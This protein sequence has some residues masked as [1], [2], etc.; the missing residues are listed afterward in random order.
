MTL[1]R[2]VVWSLGGWIGVLL[3]V[4]LAQAEVVRF[5]IFARTPL[6]GGKEFE[7]AGS[8]EV[9]TG[10]VHYALDPNLPQNRAIVDLALAPRSAAGLV[11]F[12]ADL[13]ILK[14]VDAARGNGCLLYE[15]NNRG[16]KVALSMFN[17]GGGNDLSDEKALGHGFLMRQGF[18]VVWSGWDGEL[19]PGGDRLRLAAPPAMGA[20]GPLSGLVRCEIVPSSA[21]TRS[22]INW[23]NHG[24]YRPTEGGLAQA[25]LTVRERPADPRVI[26]P[27][28]QW[29]LHVTELPEQ[30]PG[31]LP[32]VELELPAGLKPGWLYEV[33]YEARD[34]VVMGAGFAAVRDLVAAFKDGTGVDN[35]LVRDGQP[36]VRDAIGFGVSQSGRFLREFLYS[37]FNEDEHGRKVF[38]GLMP[39]VA[40][41]GL[42]SFNHRFAQPTRH[43]SQHDH[44]DYAIDRFPFAYEMQRDE[45][46]GTEDGLLKRAV[47]S[48]TTP[49]IMHTQ[50]TAE[51]WTRGGSL[52]H[53]DTAAKTDAKPPENVR[54]YTFGGTQHGPA[55]WPPTAGQGKAAAN[56]GDYKP[57]L[58]SLLLTMVTWIREGVEPPPSRV[59]S[60]SDKT[61]VGW[62]TRE[63]GFPALSG[64]IYP[65]VIRQPPRL[66]CGARWLTEGIMDR[67]PPVITGYYP[68]LVPKCG[69]DGNELGCLLP[70]EVAAPVA[71]FT[72]WNLRS[73]AAGA[74]DQL[75]S[76]TGSY[77][78]FSLNR[79][80]RQATGDLRTSLEERYGDLN[81]YLL[82]HQQAIES[83]VHAGFLLD[84]DVE[85][86]QA[87]QRDRVAP[88]FERLAG[89]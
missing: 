89:Q 26:V 46:T 16:N 18:T 15:V 76:L 43:G 86:L 51:Y 52:P 80:E 88:L 57:F 1:A 75:V 9:V 66:D 54:F 35:P 68:V 34:P 61:L 83:L 38:D 13:C 24:A 58:R 23:A 25:T 12:A 53:T 36:V 62:T 82:A 77:I 79:V 17:D 65:L 70:P 84:E 50:S 40:G 45:V 10:R 39:H 63:T 48:Q 20:D 67:Q 73:R 28:E 55:G 60:I 11:E 14:P 22:D 56:P 2:C 44:A 32:R 72:G 78:P 3:G 59:P 49:L 7:T 85:R 19:L 30:P 71:T 27:R 69:P 64:V 21:I 5:E 31:Q 4:S 81:R 37:G 6:A 74:E 33:I 8:Y 42:G 29:H 87:R 41:A 47:A